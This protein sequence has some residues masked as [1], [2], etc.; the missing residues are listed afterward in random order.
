MLTSLLL[1]LQ[2]VIVIAPIMLHTKMNARNI[3]YYSLNDHKRKYFFY[4]ARY[5]HLSKITCTSH[6]HISEDHTF[7]SVVM[8]P[9]S[10]ERP[11][12]RRRELPRPVW[13]RYVR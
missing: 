4:L 6:F 1:S 8:P 13:G 12:K 2:A 5:V 7:Y 10:Q 3:P 11:L 9:A